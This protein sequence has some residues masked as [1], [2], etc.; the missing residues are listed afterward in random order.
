M[1]YI[2]RAL[3]LLFN[4]SDCSF[5]TSSDISIKKEKGVNIEAGEKMMISNSKYFCPIVVQ[6]QIY[7][8]QSHHTYNTAKDISITSELQL[9]NKLVLGETK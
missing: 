4:A 5:Q 9:Q 6:F 2:R 1:N 7:G 8:L 3:I